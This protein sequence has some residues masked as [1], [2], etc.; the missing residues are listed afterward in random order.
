M[1]C[2][3]DDLLVA[4]SNIGCGQKRK[5]VL[6]GKDQLPTVQVGIKVSWGAFKKV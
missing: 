5:A 4:W 3:G 6:L 2:F 1:K